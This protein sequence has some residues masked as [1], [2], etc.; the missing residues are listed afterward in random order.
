MTSAATPTKIK[1]TS[2][3]T[4][5]ASMDNHTLVL[6]Q[7]KETA[8]VAQRLRG[9][10]QD[11]FVRVSELVN[12]TGAR[13]VNGTIQPPTSSTTSS[14][15]TVTVADSITGT[16]AAGSP[17]QL[18]GDSASP[19]NNQVYGT[20]GSGVKGWYA[21]G[22]GSYTPPVTT[23]GD[24]F[25]YS[26]T[27]AR[28]PVGTN[29]QVL[30]AD[31]T[32]ALGLKWAA[33]SGGGGSSSATITV[34]SLPSSTNLTTEGNLDW[35][36]WGNTSYPEANNPNGVYRKNTTAYQIFG[37]WC[38]PSGP[39]GTFNFS[40][41]WNGSWAANDSQVTL[42]SG[43]NG[44]GTYISTSSGGGIRLIVTASTVTRYLRL[45][46]SNGTPYSIICTF[47]DGTVVT[48]SG[49]V[50]VNA[51]IVIVFNSARDGAR[52]NVQIQ[53]NASTNIGFLAAT[54]GTV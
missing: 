44:V 26:T 9:D 45:Y 37:L 16:G 2:I 1:G 40:S 51:Q 3:T 53:A 4:P 11:S 30:T 43:S 36:M 41:V 39:T 27:P 23:K 13:L 24:L 20:N 12:A 52:M 14:A 47:D 7:L 46:V 32:Q 50:T 21:A 29:G 22:G 6:G 38:I 10:P 17:L 34:N 5:T 28:I 18:S 49:I 54:L 8:E 19:G 35:Q 33:A 42:A 25:G 15:G 48:S 31:S